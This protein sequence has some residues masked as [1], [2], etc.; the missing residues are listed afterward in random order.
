MHQTSTLPFPSAEARNRPSG[1]KATDWTPPECPGSLRRFVPI[2]STCMSQTNRSPAEQP[3]HRNEMNWW[4]NRKKINERTRR[5]TNAL[6]LPQHSDSN[7]KKRFRIHRF[8]VCRSI[9]ID[10]IC[11]MQKKKTVA[12]VDGTCYS[13]L[14]SRIHQR[15]S[16]PVDHLRRSNGETIHCPMWWE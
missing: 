7:Q 9:W 16:W 2:P 15:S 13:G 8:R 11:Q 1:E 5:S 4:I 6:S 10:Q 12:A 14:P 3:L